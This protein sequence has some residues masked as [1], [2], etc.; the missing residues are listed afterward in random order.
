MRLGFI[1]VLQSTNV[2]RCSGSMLVGSPSTIQTNANKEKT[3][4]IYLLGRARYFIGRID[5]TR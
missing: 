3:D 5:E 4:G 2:H 1:L